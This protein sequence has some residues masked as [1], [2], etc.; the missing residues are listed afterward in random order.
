MVRTVAASMMYEI[1]ILTILNFFLTLIFHNLFLIVIVYDCSIYFISFSPHN[2]LDL[3]R[4]QQL[5]DATFRFREKKFPNFFSLD[6]M[7]P[8]AAAP[9]T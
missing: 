5:H 3:N 2:N 7:I 4:I 1:Q 8:A 9:Y 6:L